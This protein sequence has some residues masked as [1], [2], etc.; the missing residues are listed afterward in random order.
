MSACSASPAT[1]VA[2]AAPELLRTLIYSP[3]PEWASQQTPAADPLHP[4]RRRL[5][6]LAAVL[7]A[8]PHAAPGAAISHMFTE[9]LDV[10]QRLLVMDGL[11]AA[12]CELAGRPL[13]QPLKAPL[14][15]APPPTLPPHCPVA[16]SR[17]RAVHF[18]V[19][20]HRRCAC[21]AP[22]SR[23]VQ[24]V[25]NYMPGH[26]PLQAAPAWCICSALMHG[27]MRP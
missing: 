24:D 19:E 17:R 27:H 6:S 13:L 8:A 4:H 23:P 16:C 2:K 21:S 22:A 15:A 7:A 25:Q 1:E 10:S 11:C 9:G 3:P 26:I 14:G 18:A 5:G 12:A 20:L